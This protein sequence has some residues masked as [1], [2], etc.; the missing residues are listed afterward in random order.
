MKQVA[1]LSR[2]LS[3]LEDSKVAGKDRS[4][5]KL[6]RVRAE[7][8]EFAEPAL[9]AD[10]LNSIAHKEKETTSGVVETL[11]SSNEESCSCI[12]KEVSTRRVED[13]PTYCGG[14]G[15]EV[16]SPERLT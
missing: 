11:P 16:Y 14:F 8:D 9:P 1:D 6:K 13:A 4:D 15:V 2:R 12:Q 10:G 5:D 7:G 3:M